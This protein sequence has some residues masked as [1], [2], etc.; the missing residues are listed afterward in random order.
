MSKCI[1]FTIEKKSFNLKNKDF[2]FIG[3]FSSITKNIKILK[4]GFK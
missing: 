1:L 4:C 3:Q 2:I